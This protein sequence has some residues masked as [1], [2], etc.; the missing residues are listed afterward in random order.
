MSVVNYNC[1]FLWPRTD[2]DSSLKLRLFKCSDICAEKAKQGGRKALSLAV[3]EDFFFFLSFTL[4]T[5]PMY[6]PES[7]FVHRNPSHPS[8]SLWGWTENLTTQQHLKLH[9]T[10]TFHLDLSP[11]E[12]SL[13]N[14]N[15]AFALREIKLVFRNFPAQLLIKISRLETRFLVNLKHCFTKAE[16]TFRK[17]HFAQQTV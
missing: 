2:L 8:P 7:R 16:L 13:S 12:K 10:Q 9:V 5:S 1:W 15:T 3:M 14:N 4:N 6:S 17:Q 11:S